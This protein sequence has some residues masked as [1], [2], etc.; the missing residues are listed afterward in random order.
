MA[1]GACGICCDVCGLYVRGICGTC[2]PGRG[3]EALGK[4]EIQERSLGAPCP[5]LA[6]A[7]GR[8]IDH[9]SRDCPDFP[10]A[11]FEGG[12]Y[13]F[14]EGYLTMQRRRRAERHP[15]KGA[16]LET[17]RVPSHHW[18]ALEGM[19]LQRLCARA[20]ARPY[21]PKGLLL[22]FLEE[23]LLVDIP[24]RRVEVQAHADWRPVE[25]D[26]LTLLCLVYLL[27][28]GDEPLGG[29]WVTAKELR[30]AHF[31]KGP[32]LLPLE[33]LARRYGEDLGG[34]RGAAAALGGTP[35][36]MGDAAYRFLAFP[37]IP[38]AFALWLGD[39]EFPANVS[40]YFDR[41]VEDHLP[42]DALW[43]LVHLM[44]DALVRGGIPGIRAPSSAHDRGE[45]HGTRT[46]GAQG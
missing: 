13:P 46:G 34:F 15:A 23:Y 18:E 42:A 36:E 1:T 4:A 27:H 39:E 43:G 30:A 37:K 31:F 24:G 12:P 29:R 10:C 25:S 38:V 14:S 7:M 22:P 33:P 17:V 26:L 35:L 28:V 45:P 40:V 2:G 16:S 9:C 41:S 44:T 32:H 19:D 20:G 8:G 11:R 5:I 6:C 3:R 21:P